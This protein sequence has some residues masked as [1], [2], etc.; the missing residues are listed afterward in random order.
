MVKIGRN[1]VLI[2]DYQENAGMVDFLVKNKIIEEP[3]DEIK[4][5]FVKLKVARLVKP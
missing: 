3:H 1:D 5:G 2:K 4:S